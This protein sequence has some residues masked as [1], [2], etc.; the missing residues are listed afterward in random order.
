[1][2]TVQFVSVE[3]C[4]VVEM[5][6][7]ARDSDAA[8]VRLLVDSGF[9]GD[10]AIVLS[11][12]FRRY[13]YRETD[14]ASTSGA[15]QGQQERIVLNCRIPGI[16]VDSRLIAILA[17]VE[18]LQLPPGIDGMVGLT[19]LRLFDRWGAERTANGWRFFLE[20]AA[21]ESST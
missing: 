2:A 9:T 20:K 17:D 7:V 11:S 18:P 21:G 4:D 1:V 15:L 19:F 13:K 12:A 14:P 10:S 6:I 8:H 5:D 16:L 3:D